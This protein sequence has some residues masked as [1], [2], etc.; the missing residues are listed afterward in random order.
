MAEA[1]PFPTRVILTCSYNGL[2]ATQYT[3][4]RLAPTRRFSFKADAAMYVD[5][6][7]RPLTLAS[8]ILFRNGA[9]VDYNVTE[10]EGTCV[11]P[12]PEGTTY[13]PDEGTWEYY[14]Y[15]AGSP[16]AEP[17]K[18]GSITITLVETEAEEP[19]PAP[20]V[21]VTPKAPVP[22]L[23]WYVAWLGPLIDYF[24]GLTESVVNFFAPIFAPL[25]DIA[26]SIIEFVKNPAKGIMDNIASAFKD[27]TDQSI[28]EAIV[29]TVL[30]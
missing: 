11:F 19:A 2:T 12:Y 17:S 16:T 8:I 30:S 27:T 26:N 1:K 21:V 3:S 10:E 20:V 13:I 14:A 5:G 23:P 9:S 22:T 28:Q 18:S 6:M 24:G 25:G 7:W 15:F 29:R 4:L